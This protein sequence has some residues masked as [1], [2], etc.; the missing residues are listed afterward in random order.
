MDEA[1]VILRARV[2]GKNMNPKP[3]EM[4]SHR[5]TKA[6][7]G[8]RLTMARNKIYTGEKPPLDEKLAVFSKGKVIYHSPFYGRTCPFTYH[9]HSNSRKE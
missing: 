4:Q 3:K 7:I 8:E 1:A 2:K 5:R 6:G 9:Y